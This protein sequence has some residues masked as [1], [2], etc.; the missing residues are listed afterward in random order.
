MSDAT[1]RFSDLSRSIQQGDDCA[2]DDAPS[3]LSADPF[4]GAFSTNPAVAG[5]LR[6]PRQWV[7]FDTALMDDPSRAR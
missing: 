2:P 5:C 4:M 7:W 6:Q 3:N 1:S